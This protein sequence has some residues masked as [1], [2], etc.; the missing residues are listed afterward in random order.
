VTSEAWRSLVA[1]DPNDTSLLV[2]RIRKGDRRAL[3]DLFV[4]HRDRLRRMVELRLDARLRGR[5]DASDVL[6]DAFLDAAAQLDGYLRGPEMPALL[7]LRLLVGERMA[8]YHRKHLGTKMRNAGQEVSLDRGRSPQASSA[9]LAS[10]L[11][12]RLTSPSAAA[13][14]AEQVLQVQ[15]A[16]NALDPL[17]R[18]VVALRDFEE[19]S[20]AQVAQVLGIS[21]GAGAKRYIRALKRLKAVLA[22]MPGGLECL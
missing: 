17:D 1:A 15:E 6:Q 7:W 22:T 12:G 16:L 5:V 9:A 21:E 8:I 18:E 19:L 2:E 13:V 10:M 20:R 11:L 3:T 14:R 4:H